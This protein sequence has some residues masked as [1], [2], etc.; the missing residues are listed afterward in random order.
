MFGG[1]YVNQSSMKSDVNIVAGLPG[2][3]IGDAHPKI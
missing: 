2:E 1:N 3:K